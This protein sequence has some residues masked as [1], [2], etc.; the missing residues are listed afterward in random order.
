MKS[1][2]IKLKPGVIPHIFECQKKRSSSSH[3]PRALAKNKE[4]KAI[5]DEAL[6]DAARRDDIVHLGGE[7]IKKR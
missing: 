3:K 7:N 4:Q 1:G 6:Q 5:I 2:K